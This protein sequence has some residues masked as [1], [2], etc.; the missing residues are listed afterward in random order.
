MDLNNPK[1]RGAMAIAEQLRRHKHRVYFA[2]GCVRDTVMGKTPDDYDIATTATP[3]AIEKLFKKTIAVGKQFGV[4][5]VIEGETAYEVATF[6]SDAGYQDGRHPSRV[7][8]VSPEQDALRRDFTVNGLFYDPFEKKVIDFV[9]GLEDIPRKLI[10]SIGDPAKRFEEDKLRLIRAVRFASNLGFEIEPKTWRALGERVEE[11]RSV[12][13][14]RV[15]DELVK[16]FT[17][18]GAGRGL[19]LLSACGILKVVLP[20]IEALRG[21]EQPAKFHPEGDVFAHTKLLL[22]HL[23]SPSVILALSAL[24][25]DVGKPATLQYKDGRPT[26]YEH[27]ARG[28]A[29]VREIMRRLRF[30]NQEIEA[31]SSCVENHMRFMDVK[32]MRLGKLKQL[33][34]RPTFADELELHRIDC[35]ASHGMLDNHVFLIET[36]RSLAAEE[37]K[38]KPFLNG[39]DLI[40]AHV[41]PGPRMKEILDAAYEEQLEGSLTD[42]DGALE[43]LERYLKEHPLNP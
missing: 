23:S 42:R 11:I 2:G 7:E 38:P 12:S 4:M 43:W 18:P 21:V 19:E 17:R 35:L 29:M 1:A 14:E 32:K 33:I 37:I 27:A 5:I 40:A 15:R 3:A 16:I 36:A 41:M 22:D 9:Q 13:A 34:A 25:H 26:F 30:S 39:H 24:F 28:A 10:R 20:E 31:V 8:F 6:R